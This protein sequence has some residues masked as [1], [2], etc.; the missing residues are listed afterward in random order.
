M[1]RWDADV[2]VGMNVRNSKRFRS[3]DASSELMCTSDVDVD[4][5]CLLLS[6]PRERERNHK[7]VNNVSHLA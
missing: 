6:G 2:A 7:P 4:G 3:D 1:I 5:V